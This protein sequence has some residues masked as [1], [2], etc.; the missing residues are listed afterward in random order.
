MH[1]NYIYFIDSVVSFIK[2]EL[3][4]SDNEKMFHW[5]NGFTKNCLDDY[6]NP[7]YMISDNVRE[8]ICEEYLNTYLDAFTLDLYLDYFDENPFKSSLADEI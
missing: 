4:H 2:Q 3:F 7:R 8:K 6:G 5:L 1:K